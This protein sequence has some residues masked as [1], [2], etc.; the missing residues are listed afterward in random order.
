MSSNG[1]IDKAA[2][3][4]LPPV[5]GSP[6]FLSEGQAT[7]AATYLATNWAKAVG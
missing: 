2:A 6:V 4:K 3:A 1:S 5:S 7:S